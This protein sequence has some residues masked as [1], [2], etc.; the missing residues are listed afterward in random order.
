ML[1]LRSA[2]YIWTRDAETKKFIENR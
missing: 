1:E 2:D